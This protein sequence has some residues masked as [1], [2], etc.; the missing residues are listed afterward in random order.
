MGQD[1]RTRSHVVGNLATPVLPHPT[2]TENGEKVAAAAARLLCKCPPRA[3]PYAGPGK[4]AGPD[5]V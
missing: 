3:S 1:M 4:C 5:R 2:R